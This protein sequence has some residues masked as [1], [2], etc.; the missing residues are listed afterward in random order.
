MKTMFARL[1]GWKT[2]I[3]AVLLIL[4]EVLRFEGVLTQEVANSLEVFLG[5]AGLAALRHAIRK[6]E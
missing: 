2:H 5:A 4:V 3:T 1:D 6:V